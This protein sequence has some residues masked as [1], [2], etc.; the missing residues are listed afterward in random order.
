MKIGDWD[1]TEVMAGRFGLDGGAMFGVVPRTLWE[2]RLPPDDHN[3]IPMVMRCLLARGHNRTIL[4]DV[5]SGSGYDEKTHRIYAFDDMVPLANVV[6]RAGVH[7][8]EVTDVLL[9][10]LHFDHGA[11]VVEANSESWQLVFP[12]AVHHVQ[13]SQW[14]HAFSPN[15]RDRASYYPQRLQAMKDAGVLRLHDGPW[16]LCPGVELDVFNGHTP[17]QQLPRFGEGSDTVFF[18]GDLIPTQHHIPT[19]YIMSYDLDPVL[20]M[21]EKV[22]ILERAEEQDWILFFEH[23]AHLA[24][25]RL[26]REGKKLI[27]SETYDFARV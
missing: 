4:V 3:R 18:C 2:K 13:R 16:T 26:V 27:P 23:D 5:G 19:P 8:T 17:G 7:A 24:G 10:H 1:I 25:C 9:T 14:T 21:D 22:R 12:K 6:E 11:G 15:P 20:A